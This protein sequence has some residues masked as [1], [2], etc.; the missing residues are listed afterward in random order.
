MKALKI[1]YT[2]IKTGIAAAQRLIWLLTKLK[3][4]TAA[5]QPCPAEKQFENEEEIHVIAPCS[6]LLYG[7]Y[8]N[9]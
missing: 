3:A 7:T 2:E 8:K 4:F 9:S 1:D 5:R 6:G